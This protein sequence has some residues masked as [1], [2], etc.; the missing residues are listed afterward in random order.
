MNTERVMG[1]S[2]GWQVMMIATVDRAPQ[3]SY[4]PDMR[5]VADF[6]VADPPGRIGYATIDGPVSSVDVKARTEEITVRGPLAQV[7]AK[8]LAKGKRIYIEGRLEARWNADD[9]RKRIIF[10]SG[11][12]FVGA[13][14][15]VCN[16]A[17][18]GRGVT[19][20]VANENLPPALRNNA[21]GLF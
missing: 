14:P 6:S 8:Y 19:R 12:Y 18:E 16:L 5:A 17:D 21:R 20:W 13:P 2:I 15:E 7:C 10:A 4:L 9:K 11:I 3:V 1:S